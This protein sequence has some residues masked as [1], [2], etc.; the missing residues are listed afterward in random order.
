MLLQVTLSR[1]I[2]TW[3]PCKLDSSMTCTDAGNADIAWSNISAPAAD[4][5]AI[6]CRIIYN[7]ISKCVSCVGWARFSAHALATKINTKWLAKQDHATS[8]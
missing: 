7:L 6:T 4:G 3:H 1:K 2:K 5:P 8:S